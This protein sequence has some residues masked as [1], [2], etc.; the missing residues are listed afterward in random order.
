MLDP[1]DPRSA[2][3]SYGAGKVKPASAYAPAEYGKFYEMDPQESNAQSKTWWMRAQNL[4]LAYST[5]M[6]GGHFEREHQPDEFLLLLI[7]ADSSA[8]L[9]TDSGTETIAGMSVTIVPPGRSA[10]RITAG[11]RVVRIF[12][13]ESADLIDLCVNRDS[14]RTSHPNVEQFRPW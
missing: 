7:D 1:A 4:I 3:P 14:Y 10:L 11:G 9:T 5:A 8:E 13:I 12:S 2:L 6:A